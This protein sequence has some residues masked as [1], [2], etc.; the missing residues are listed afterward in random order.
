MNDERAIA[1]FCQS[2]AFVS[3]RAAPR[4][5]PRRLAVVGES[6]RK[7]VLPARACG[8]SKAHNRA[9]RKCCAFDKS[10]PSSQASLA[11]YCSQCLRACVCVQILAAG[12]KLNPN[13]NIQFAGRPLFSAHLRAIYIRRACRGLATAVEICYK[14]APSLPICLS[15]SHSARGR[16]CFAAGCPLA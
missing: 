7:I 14:L 12:A 11:Q 5:S 15:I 13:L 6:R 2:L 8:Q 16:A 10:S 4:V 3:R 1:H 9:T